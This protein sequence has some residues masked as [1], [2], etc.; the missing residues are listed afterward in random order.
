MSSGLHAEQF[1]DFFEQLQGYRPFP[2]QERLATRVCTGAWPQVIDLPTASGKTACID[3]AL[4]ALAVRQ[5]EAARRIFFVVDRRVIVAEAYQ[6]ARKIRDKL[7]EALAE[8]SVLGA[9]ARE[10]RALAGPDADPLEAYELRGGIYRDD[11]WV[12]SPL[13]PAVIA[14][15]VDQI[16]S[17][18]LFRGY[19][20]SEQ[21]WPIYAGLIGNDSLVVL[22]EAHC[23]QPFGETLAAVERYRGAEWAET[24]LG[25]PFQFVEMTATPSRAM[26]EPFRLDESDRAHPV[27]QRRLRARK[28]TLLVKPV[29]GKNE[30]FPKLAEELAAQ[31]VQLA[32]DAGGKRAAVLVNR[33]G[34]AKLVHQKLQAQGFDAL[35]VI[36]RMRPMDRDWLMDQY[37]SL[38]SG[39]ERR[40]ADALRFV[41]S[42]QCLEVGADLDFDV[43]VSECASIDA[44]VQRFGRLDR[45]GKFE[46]AQG[47]IVIGSWQTDARKPDAVYGEALA[48]T[49]AWLSGLSESKQVDMGIEAQP[50]DPLTVAQQLR[51][52]SKSESA[53]LRMETQSAPVLLPAHLDALVQ[54]S[55]VPEPSPAVEL[56]LHGPDDRAADVQVVWR[57]DLDDSN[58]EQWYEIVSLCPPVSREAMPVQIGPFKRW[59]AGMSHVDLEESDLPGRDEEVEEKKVSGRPWGLI[60]R[61]EGAERKAEWTGRHVRPGDTVVLPV[62]RGGWDV[63]GHVP[64]GQPIDVG[65]TARL[66]LRR[67]LCFRLHPKLIEQWPPKDADRKGLLELAKNEGESSSRD[68]CKQLEGYRAQIPEF[69][70]LV[71]DEISKLKRQ[72]LTSY[73][74]RKGYVI[75]GWVSHRKNSTEEGTVL[76]DEHGKQV[77]SAALRIASP[78]VARELTR[79]IERAAELHDT[80]KADL[81]FQAWLRGGDE[82]AARFAPHPV[83]KSGLPRLGKQTESGLPKGFRHELLSLL[84]ARH[85]EVEETIRELVLHL[86]ASHHGRCRPFAPVVRDTGAECVEFGGVSVCKAERE[87]DAAHRLSAGVAERFWSLTRRY[88]WWGLAY[89][90]ALLRLADWE[91]SDATDTEVMA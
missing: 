42:T 78:L 86:V 67:K 58:R 55:P 71:L 60:W 75:E 9:V 43:M 19:G 1:G 40:E 68:F 65:D 25:R 85:A 16:G 76:L 53:R 77:R 61:G 51:L 49:W 17:S 46:R 7:C 80:G 26:E 79:A 48:H 39:V 52:M 82:F 89:L 90:D 35:L 21:Q 70:Y 23:S 54:T 29:P 6:R 81:R 31:V 36:G 57:A 66:E 22:D 56:F 87:T 69:L 33:I 63:L 88:G 18:L 28:P 5:G 32:K 44:L 38:K 72:Q 14:S 10:L 2:W 64:E 47:Q 37:A 12:R 27:L 24:A 73:P 8:T 84:F 34:T 45:L 41:V 83:A 62:A 74:D 59:I 3:I 11:E 30:D 15:T 50:G 20:V 4:F 91:A 13:Q